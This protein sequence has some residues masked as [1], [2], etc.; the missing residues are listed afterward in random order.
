MTISRKTWAL[1]LAAFGALAISASSAWAGCG[2]AAVKPAMWDRSGAAGDEARLI[3]VNNGTPSIIGLWS[4]EFFAGANM[5]D[6]GY[7]QWHSD[8]TEI[9]NSGA[10]APAT[11]N[12]CLGV[13]SQTGPFS[14][15]LNHFALSYD[16]TSG[17]LNAW[18]HA[19]FT[20]VNARSPAR[21]AEGPLRGRQA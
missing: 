17:A 10:R 18:T 16:Q 5:I 2:A 4:I 21:R 13:W 14:Y 7:A 3:R 15:H 8:G 9:M 6:F 11:E 12:F 19:G 1:G 20:A